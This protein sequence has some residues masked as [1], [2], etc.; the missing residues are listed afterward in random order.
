MANRQTDVRRIDWI[1][2]EVRLRDALRS[3]RTDEEEGLNT[4]LATLYLIDEIL[5]Q[6]TGRGTELSN[7]ITCEQARRDLHSLGGLEE[8]I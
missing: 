5:A 3:H 1:H 8:D 7:M 4:R 2:L 6:E